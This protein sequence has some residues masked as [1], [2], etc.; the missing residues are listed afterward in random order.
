M[1]FLVKDYNIWRRDYEIDV[2]FT[3][4]YTPGLKGCLVKPKD[5]NEMASMGGEGI[6]YKPNWRAKLVWVGEKPTEDMLMEDSTTKKEKAETEVDSIQGCEYMTARV[7]KIVN[8]NQGIMTLRKNHIMFH[9]EKLSLDGQHY[10]TQDNLYTL[11]Q[12][13][14]ILFCYC[15]PLS[16]PT[17]VDGFEVNY[18][19]VQAWKGRK[20]FALNKELI[21]EEETRSV[22]SSIPLPSEATHRNLIGTVQQ[23]ENTCLGYLVIKSDDPSLR[24]Q[25]VLVSKNRLYINGAK[26]R[27][28]ESLFMHLSI[29]DTVHCDVVQA[30][31]EQSLSTYN[32]IA[33]LA[34]Q[35]VTPDR[36]EINAEI[37]KKTQSYRGKVLQF[38][39]TKGQG[40]TGGVVQIIGGPNKIGEMVVFDRGSTYVY[41]SSM[42][43]ADLS[44]V[45]KLNDKV[46]LEIAELEPSSLEFL[47][48]CEKFKA[49]IKYTAPMVWIGNFPRGEDEDILA[50]SVV[51][52]PFVQK[53][54][55]TLDAF[56]S[57]VKGH[58]PPKCTKGSPAPEAPALPPNVIT[59]KVIELKKHDPSSSNS[60]PGVEHGIVKIENGPYINEKAFFH[61]SSLFCWGHNCSKADLLYLIDGSE[62]MRLEVQGG[63]NNKAVPYKV[64][65]A[66]IGPHKNE[67]N[68]ESVAM[69]G[70]PLFVSWLAKHSLTVEQFLQVVK[71][72]MKPRTYFP[73]PSESHQARLANLLYAANGEADAGILR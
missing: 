39:E 53:R 64:T 60:D 11:L 28:K 15:K 41:G 44:Y 8:K 73:L 57:L 33:V 14:D 37:T 19:A 25:K 54:G 65:S 59:G 18:E 26:L 12:L 62:T 50:A 43:L 61:R 70:N 55:L 67:K 29:G 69:P 20:V 58:L 38:S 71:G 2:K 42:R 72:E 13:G 34:W 22:K 66:W 32:W 24:G 63:T 40:V 3:A 16:P 52:T 6:S 27:Y 5:D 17:K 21:S 1:T 51:I 31:P 23:L 36:E 9:I 35:G 56:M 30:N 7:E 46:Q 49:E 48:N 4:V 47:T 45:I 68:K 10:T